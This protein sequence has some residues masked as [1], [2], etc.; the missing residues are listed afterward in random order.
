METTE[1][2]EI[3]DL[4]GWWAMMMFWHSHFIVFIFLSVEW[5]QLNGTGI[6]TGKWKWNWWEAEYFINCAGN[7]ADLYKLNLFI[8][9][10]N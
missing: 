7:A 2:A 4:V 6:L 3:R 10:D 5:G 8:W 1:K 9:F